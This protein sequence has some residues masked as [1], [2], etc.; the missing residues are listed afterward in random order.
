M[1]S[2]SAATL[3]VLKSAIFFDWSPRA[4]DSR[5]TSPWKKSRV[6]LARSVRM[7]TFSCRISETSSLAPLAAN[8]GVGAD[9]GDPDDDRA[10]RAGPDR[11][12]GLEADELDPVAHVAD[13]LA[14][15]EVGLVGVEADALR[16]VVEVGAGH[17]PLL[18]DLD[19]LERIDLGGGVRELARDLLR[20]GEQARRGR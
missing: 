7:R 5:S 13:D 20:L 16:Q 19:L 2:G 1:L 9:E 12:V 10:R 6:S 17:D 14:D 18:D 8:C 15:R 11:R 4:A 3:A